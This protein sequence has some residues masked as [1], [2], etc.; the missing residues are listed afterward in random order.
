MVFQIHRYLKNDKIVGYISLLLSILFFFSVVFAQRV[1]DVYF[2]TLYARRVVATVSLR[3][4][5]KTRFPPRTISEWK[6]PASPSV[7]ASLND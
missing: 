6:S 4:A 3:I 1:P 2:L 5:R 7:T